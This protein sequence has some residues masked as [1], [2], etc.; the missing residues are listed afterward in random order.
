[1]LSIQI[2]YSLLSEARMFWWTPSLPIRGGPSGSLLCLARVRIRLFLL[3][4]EEGSGLWVGREGRNAVGQFG[5]N[6]VQ[7]SIMSICHPFAICLPVSLPLPSGHEKLGGS[8]W[9]WIPMVAL[10]YWVT[11][12]FLRVQLMFWLLLWYFICSCFWVAFLFARGWLMSPPFQRVHPP[13]RW[14]IT[15]HFS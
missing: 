4:L 13:P 1:M 7:G 12:Y 10:T 11:L 9:I 6:A 3:F 15:D 2:V 5:W 14:P 8:C